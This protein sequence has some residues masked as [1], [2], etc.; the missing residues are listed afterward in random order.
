MSDTIKELK[1]QLETHPKDE[2][3]WLAL[4]NAYVAANRLEDAIDAFSEG[5]IC[6]PFGV[7]CYHMR[8]RKYLTLRKCEFSN[9]YQNNFQVVVLGFRCSQRYRVR[10]ISI[11][12][13]PEELALRIT[14]RPL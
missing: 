1:T 2:T 10:S 9:D 14:R 4:G 6:N 5:I 3:L 11:W 7:D 12:F 8:A 13:N